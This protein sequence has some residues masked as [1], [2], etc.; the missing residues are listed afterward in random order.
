MKIYQLQLKC[1][2]LD[3]MKKFYTEDLEMELISDAETYF[4]VRA[5]TTKLIFELDNHSP[6]YHVCF[7]TNSEYYDKMYVKLAERKLLLPDED[8]H[9]SMFW[10]GKQAYFHDPDGNILEMLER[11]FHWGENRPKS[12]WY[13][14]GEI[15]L[16]VPSV[17]D[18]QNLLFSKVSDNQKRKVKPLLFM[19]INRGF[20]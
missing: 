2:K 1:F 15:G 8:G 5:G 14:V 17:K 10:Q 7:R 4:A 11:P 12:S 16:P 6:Y 20:L 3:E 13:D 18:M 9:Y 19:E